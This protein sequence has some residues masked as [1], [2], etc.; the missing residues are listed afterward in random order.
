MKIGNNLR[1]FREEAGL[2][3]KEASAALGVSIPTLG[4]WENDDNEPSFEHLNKISELYKKSI[5]EIFGEQKG[6]PL[7]TPVKNTL[8]DKVIDLLNS[9][10]LLNSANSYD[11]LDE[12]SQTMIKSAINKIIENKKQNS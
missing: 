6:K 3:R 10:G 8:L 5:S 11:E 2:D 4:H 1:R 9:E 12:H 7:S